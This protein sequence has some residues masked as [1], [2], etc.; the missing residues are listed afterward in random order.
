MYPILLGTSYLQST[1]LSGTSKRVNQ[2]YFLPLCTTPS[3]GQGIRTKLKANV[4][5]KR[6][7]KLS[8]SNETA[9]APHTSLERGWL[10]IL[11]LR[12]V[13]L[14]SPYLGM[15]A[16]LRHDTG[17]ACLMLLFYEIL[18]VWKKKTMSEVG[19]PGQ[20]LAIPKSSC[21]RPTSSLPSGAASL[22]SSLSVSTRHATYV[23]H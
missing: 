18:H 17:W 2:L 14:P 5:C 13:F 22:F 6:S 21:Q 16:L 19:G 20:S 3:T 9:I 23:W 1:L 7:P 4:K 15:K 12:V 8:S 10:V 11:E